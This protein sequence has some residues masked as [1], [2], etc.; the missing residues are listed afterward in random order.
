M[1]ELSVMAFKRLL[2]IQIHPDTTTR[3]YCGS[4]NPRMLKSRE[5]RRGD[6]RQKTT[7]TSVLSRSAAQQP[8]PVT[9]AVLLLRFWLHG[10]IKHL[11]SFQFKKQ[12]QQTPTFTP[13][14]DTSTSNRDI[15]AKSKQTE[16]QLLLHGC[17]SPLEFEAYS[18]PF[19][20]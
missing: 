3:S 16:H 15:L 14:T 10:T 11:N 18:I 19:S 2:H 1:T 8:G 17:S 7:N 9:S 5:K 20:R 6:L 12:Q 13:F 4:L